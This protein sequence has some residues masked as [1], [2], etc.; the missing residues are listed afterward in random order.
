MKKGVFISYPAMEGKTFAHPWHSTRVYNNASLKLE[1][2][3]GLLNAL[4]SFVPDPGRAVEKI[5]LRATALGIFDIFANGQRVGTLGED[6]K[7]ETPDEYKPGWT[8]Y[9]KRVFEFEYDITGLCRTDGIEQNHVVAEV[10]PGWWTGRIS[11]GFYGSK[12]TAFA[13]EVEIV[14]EDGGSELLA[15]GDGDAWRVTV[16]GP[17]L[18]ADIW[19]GEYYDSRIPEPSIYHILL[20]LR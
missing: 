17:V 10:S 20:S 1:P 5:L 3:E 4:C 19:D 8:D 18:R 9:R 12:P 11:F 7:Y 6:G 2:G 14:Y 13:G 15:S 16:G